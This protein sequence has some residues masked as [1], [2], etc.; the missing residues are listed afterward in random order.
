MMNQAYTL[1]DLLRHAEKSQAVAGCDEC[2]AHVRVETFVEDEPGL[3]H[4][5]VV[6]ED[7]CPVVPRRNRAARRQ[8]RQRR[9]G[10]R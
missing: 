10:K 8:M 2:N 1:S 9:T 3:S 4:I 6:H 5:T 7:H